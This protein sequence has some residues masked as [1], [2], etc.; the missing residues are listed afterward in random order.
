[1]GKRC[2]LEECK[3]RPDML[4]GNCKQ[5]TECFCTKH[6][7]P[8]DHKC[9]NLD[10]FKNDLREKNRQKLNDEKTIPKKIIKI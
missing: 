4:I 8:E 6:R 1:M 7:L 10:K 9:S 5:C 2:F 3:K